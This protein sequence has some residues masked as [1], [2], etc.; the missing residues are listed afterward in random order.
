M[1]K[2]G[3]IQCLFP[4]GC[5]SLINFNRSGEMQHSCLLIRFAM[6]HSNYMEDMVI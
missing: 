2:V 6:K 3:T 1:G 5:V 4:K